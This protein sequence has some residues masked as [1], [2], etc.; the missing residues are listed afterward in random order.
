MK[1]IVAILLLFFS[2]GTA[3]ACSCIVPDE[4]Q[5]SEALKTSSVVFRGTVASTDSTFDRDRTNFRFVVSTAWKGVQKGEIV[6]TSASDSAACGYNFQTGVTYT[7]YAGGNPPSTNSCL[8]L[9]VDEK[10]V[11]NALGE[12]KSFEGSSN[13]APESAGSVWS[14]LWRK[15]TRIFS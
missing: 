10:R 2:Y 11:R 5:K 6:I 9:Q 15:I 13:P 1:T 7:V 12:G 4:K 3:F 8:M 14:R